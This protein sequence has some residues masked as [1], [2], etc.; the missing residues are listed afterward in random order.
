MTK[1]LFLREGF[2]TSFHLHEEK[3]ETMYILNGKGYIQ[4]EDRKEYFAK[5]DT[6]R[7]EPEVPHSIVAME[8]TI[9]HEVS[10]P[11]LDDTKRLKDVYTRAA[12]DKS[13][14]I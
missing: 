2:H 3:D 12:K 10:T 1:E 9:L 5:N 11:H 4:F 6:V 8:N 7:I 13:K 14:P